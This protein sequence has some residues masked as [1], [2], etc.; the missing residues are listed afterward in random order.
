MTIK[1]RKASENDF[2]A[3]LILI[4]ELALYENALEKVTNSIEQM[5][6][7]QELFQC[8]I[9]ETETDEIIGFA[10]FYFTYYTWIGKS[11]YLDDL[12]V[13]EAFRGHKIGS[14]FLDKVFEVAKQSNC[15]RVRWQVLNWNTP[16][17]EMYK[18]YNANIDNEWINCDFD[19][20]GIQDFSI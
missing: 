7:D 18:K 2:E 14:Q 1:I 17:I 20:Q 4:K 19:Y 6:D 5:V 3:I 8:Y 9:A 13:R 16:A 15:K 11:L 12:Y 10:L